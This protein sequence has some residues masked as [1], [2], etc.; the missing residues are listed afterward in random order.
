MRTVPFVNTALGGFGVCAGV[1][2]RE[3]DEL[4]VEF[5]V[6]EALL[7]LVNGKFQVVRIPLADLV[8][9][10][11]VRGF[12]VNSLWVTTRIVIESAHMETMADFPD[13]RHGQIKLT[14]PR[15]YRQDAGLLLEE[16]YR[17]MEAEEPDEVPQPHATN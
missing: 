2:R 11:F 8:T 5:Q 6:R 15:R 3:P 4:V 12:D 13:M 7:G 14:I 16:L 1:L 9:V 10:D 17:D